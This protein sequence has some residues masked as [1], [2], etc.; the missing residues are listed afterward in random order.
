MAARQV[1]HHAMWSAAEKNQAVEP[2]RLSPRRQEAK[3]AD[4][5]LVAGELDDLQASIMLY[6]YG[7]PIDAAVRSVCTQPNGTSFNCE[8]KRI[9][10]ETVDFAYRSSIDAQYAKTDVGSS[11]QCD[12]DKVGAFKGVI[13]SQNRD[14]FQVAVDPSSK[15]LLS[16]KL[17]EFA[18]DRGIKHDVSIAAGPQVTRVEPKNSAC[19]FTDH[20]GVLRNGQIVNLSQVDLLVR[21]RFIPPI[22]ALIVFQ[23]PRRYSAEVTSVFVIGFMA[24]FCNPIAEKDFTSNIRFTD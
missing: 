1:L 11:V 15:S 14:G 19:C 12:L 23:G 10:S 5:K 13:A 7:L 6:S 24:R 17:A 21:T 2:T 9:S 20:Q 16:A 18:I 4:Q 3:A 8:T 22:P